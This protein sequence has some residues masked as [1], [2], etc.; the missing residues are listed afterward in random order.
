MA[1]PVAMPAPMAIP[2]AS[3]AVPA[4]PMAVP[5]A[6]PAPNIFEGID[7]LPSGPPRRR[8]RGGWGPFLVAIILLGGAAGAAVY[9]WPQLEPLLRQE[10]KQAGADSEKNT[11][12]DGDDKDRASSKDASSRDKTS[13]DKVTPPKDRDKS[14]TPKDKTTPKDKD[15]VVAPKDKPPP[16]KDRVVPPKDKDT[17]SPPKDRPPPP[18]DKDMTS[19]PKDKPSDGTKPPPPKDKPSDGVKP[20]PPKD[21]DDPTKKPPIANSAF[22]RRALVISVHNYLFANPLTV[23]DPTPSGRN[24]QNLI[25]RLSQTRGFRISPNQ[26]GFLSDAARPPRF[27]SYSPIKATIENTITEFLDTSREQDR[28]MILFAGHAAEVEGKVYLCPIEGDLTTVAGMIPLDWVYKKL[29]ECKAQQKLLIVDVC[30]VNTARGEERASF[31]AMSPKMD[32]AFKNPPAGVQVWVSCTEGQQSYEFEDFKING[33]VFMDSLYQVADRGLEGV[34]QKHD[35]PIPVD[36]FVEQ[37]NALMKKELEPLKLTQTSRL[38]GTLPEKQLKFDAEVKSAPEVGVVPAARTAQ[39]KPEI[40]RG[41]LKELSVPP[42]KKQQD[43]GL[44]RYEAL[45]PFEADNLDKFPPDNTPSELRDA[46][47][48]A[49][50]TLWACCPT[51]A[52]P[53]LIEAVRKIKLSGELK[54]D[55]SMLKESYRAPAGGG[56]AENQFKNAIQ[57]DQKRVASIL[58]VLE[59]ELDSLKKAG[60]MKKDAPKR[61]QANYDFVLARLQM[62]IAYVYEYTSMLGAMR[63]EFPPRDPAVHSGWRLASRKKLGGDGTGRKLSQAADKLLNELIAKYPNTPWEILAKREKMSA[64]GLEWKPN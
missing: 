15:R 16:P 58:R 50:A 17:A 60:E 55:L 21:K 39:A 10:D 29:D 11:S 42:V 40:V 37:V 31:G 18:K 49:Q 27:Q 12:K 32:L 51:P 5:V 38:S 64:L 61:L 20:P 59:E 22:P 26:V 9:Y 1:V 30:R 41:I 57:D 54:G 25:G 3:A 7:G 14:S 36:K 8:R 4:V 48:H 23:G 43:E 33:G 52:P 28:V 44:L 19:P 62:Q 45:P 34:I 56:N 13:T 6:A 47:A 35:D 63:K 53:E 24:V 46:I 2:V